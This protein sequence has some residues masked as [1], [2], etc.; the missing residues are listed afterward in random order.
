MIGYPGNTSIVVGARGFWRACL[1]TYGTGGHSGSRADRP[2]NAVVKASTLVHALSETPLP[3]AR[4]PDFD[5]GPKLTVTAISG[6]D[7]YTSIPDTCSLRVDV[8]LTP[9]FGA[10]AA[11]EIVRSVCAGRRPSASQPGADDDRGRGPPTGFRRRRR[12]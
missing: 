3:D 4:G 11:E 2:D 9:S 7:G 10:G 8:R 12:S 1:C 5:F 6:G